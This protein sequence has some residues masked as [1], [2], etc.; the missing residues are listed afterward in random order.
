MASFENPSSPNSKV[1]TPFSLDTEDIFEL[2]NILWSVH[3]NFKNKTLENDR[4]LTE[5][6]ALKSR[7]EQLESDLVNQIEIQKECEKAKHTAKIL[8][9]KYSML[10]KVLED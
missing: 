10:E 9:E 7:N 8:N 1:P 5:I 3:G 2:K 4:L 6:E